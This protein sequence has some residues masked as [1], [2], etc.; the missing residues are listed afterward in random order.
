MKQFLPSFKHEGQSNMYEFNVANI[1]QQ[2]QTSDKKVI[3]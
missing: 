3:Y 2:I 1:S